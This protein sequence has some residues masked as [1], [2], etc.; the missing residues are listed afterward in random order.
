M[1]IQFSSWLKHP[2]YFLFWFLTGIFAWSF[3]FSSPEENSIQLSS[4]SAV[5][6]DL[7]FERQLAQLDTA[8]FDPEQPLI[9][10]FEQIEETE[11][12][13][14][15]TL[16]L[17]V[18]LDPNQLDTHQKQKNFSYSEV[19]A[20]DLAYL[21]DYED[22]KSCTEP[23][24]Y[25]E[26]ALQSPKISEWTSERK[27]ES[28]SL[29]RSCIAF[30]LNSF[31]EVTTK[32]SALTAKA[33]GSLAF[34]T[35]TKPNGAPLMRGKSRIKNPTPCISSKF[36][37]VTY[38]AYVDVMECLRL[39]PKELL[40]KIYNES[41]FYMNALGGA[42][43]GGIGQLTGSAIQQVNSIYPK[44][45]E[46]MIQA[47]VNNPDGA[48]ARV[49]K[50]KLLIAPVKAD[51]GSRCSLMWPI[52]NPLR[53]L[54][55][56]AILTRYNTRYVSGLNYVAGEEMLDENGEM[57]LAKGTADEELY[58]K[59][60]EHG[61][62]KKLLQLGMKNVNLH[63]FTSMI[64]LAGYNSG[65]GTAMNA[66]V[67]YLDLRLDANRSM[68][69][70]KYNLTAAH[71][72]FIDTKDLVKEARLTLLSSNIKPKENAKSKADKVR[73]R[74]NLPATWATAHTKTFPEYLALKLN[75]YD[76]KSAKPFLVYGYPGYLTA[77]ALKNKMIRDTFQAAGVEPNHCTLPNFLSVK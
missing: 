37:N 77:L 12:L 31:P 64:V 9:S 60:K 4:F 21:T 16:D 57:I 56:S 70:G 73:R 34:A 22:L 33:N 28:A 39:D 51:T 11:K 47:G 2:T 6:G 7:E 1:E 15:G 24:K 68:K 10:T 63:Q 43:D 65:I 42:M 20:D 8:E 26:K 52:E 32:N 36:V 44:Y 62:R 17:D 66:F 38:N 50:N 72:N 69:S 41:G 19:S 3:S 59:M 13:F 30:A 58:G 45:I 35:C 23:R 29:P 67:K 61:I 75:S 48:C 40:P 74:K 76:G 14:N 54:V 25:L 5:N 18:E 49:V 46:Q 53:N 71:F 55:Y 27:I